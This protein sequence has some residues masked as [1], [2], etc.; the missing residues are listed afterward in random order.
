MY[1]DGKKNGE[2]IYYY[3]NSGDVWDKR[4]YNN[5]KLVNVAYK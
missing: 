1:L 4:H 3:D 5:G 2:W